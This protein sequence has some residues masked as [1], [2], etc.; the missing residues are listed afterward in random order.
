MA[1]L[2]TG[3]LIFS[4]IGSIK[5]RDIRL[6][7]YLH[8]NEGRLIPPTGRL[9]GPPPDLRYTVDFTVTV[10]PTPMMDDS[11]AI[12][13][14]VISSVTT[15]SPEGHL[16][17]QIKSESFAVVPSESRLVRIGETASYVITPRGKGKKKLLIYAK[18]FPEAL[19]H[20]ISET[21]LV[22]PAQSFLEFERVI[23]VSVKPTFWGLSDQALSIMQV[24]S[25]ILG[26]PS[27]VLLFLTRWL[28]SRKKHHLRRT[29]DENVPEA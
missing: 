22:S 12:V 20:G 25:V 7:L 27:I 23:D 1:F 16:S 4:T 28:D 10:C 11:D 21:Q 19:G 13:S 9:L 8:S 14:V 29:G 15:P 3:T 6:P 5:I 2:A 17:V 24:V 18:W 26:L